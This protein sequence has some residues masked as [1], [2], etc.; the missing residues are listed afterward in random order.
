MSLDVGPRTSTSLLSNEDMP[1]SPAASDRPGRAEV[2]PAGPWPDRSRTRGGSGT[3][4]VP[5]GSLATRVPSSSCCGSRS[6]AS[7]SRRPATAARRSNRRA[8]GSRAL[9]LLAK[10]PPSG[11][12]SPDRSSRPRLLVLS[13]VTPVP[14]QRRATTSAKG[15]IPWPQF[16]TARPRSRSGP[17]P[18]AATSVRP[19]RHHHRLR[20]LPAMSWADVV[21]AIVSATPAQEP[22]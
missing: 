22:R 21:S 9:L 17:M 3:R 4:A 8:A 16:G 7:A 20:S 12:A 10:A 19:C 13:L 2:P 14:R 6:N 15:T 11:P 1:W 5:P 18:S